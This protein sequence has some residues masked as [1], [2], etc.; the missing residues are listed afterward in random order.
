MFTPWFYNTINVKIDYRSQLKLVRCFILI[1][2][3]LN[4]NA[5]RCPDSTD[6]TGEG[7]KV[8]LAMTDADLLY[9]RPSCATVVENNIYTLADSCRL[10]PHP[11]N[12]PRK[13]LSY[14]DIKDYIVD[15]SEDDVECKPRRYLKSRKP[16]DVNLTGKFMK[17]AS[18]MSFSP[19]SS[20]NNPEKDTTLLT[21]SDVTRSDATIKYG[22]SSSDTPP[23]LALHPKPAPSVNYKL[24]A[25]LPYKVTARPPSQSARIDRPSP[26]HVVLMKDAKFDD[27]LAFHEQTGQVPFRMNAKQTTVSKSLLAN[28]KSHNNSIYRSE[29]CLAGAEFP[30][31]VKFSSLVKN[32]FSRNGVKTE[33]ERKKQLHELVKIL[34][35]S[36]L[37]P[38]LQKLRGVES[39]SFHRS[40]PGVNKAEL[41]DY[42]VVF[43]TR[44]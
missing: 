6:S 24:P 9:C 25:S 21:N 1:S 32:D 4:I 15:E 8:C 11:P 27:S 44:L 31:N 35:Q 36:T 33:K 43:G 16:L 18:G 5:K 34:G 29:P 13:M 42:S 37:T 19:P 2:Q 30:N 3:N 28:S 20:S 12:E 22:S 40:S 39:R 7:A 38:Y 26:R 17:R 41:I 10:Q 23:K 14:E